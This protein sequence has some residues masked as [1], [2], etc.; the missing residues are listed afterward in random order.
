MST[1]KAIHEKVLN[2]TT[3]EELAA[4]YSEWAEKYDHDLLNEMEYVAPGITG[5]LLLSHLTDTS[6]TILDAGCG[7]GIVGEYLHGHG[8]RAID[9]LDYSTEMLEKAREKQVYRRLMQG[10]L[11]DRLDIADNTYDAIISVG[12]FTCGHVG[13][14]AFDELIRITKPGGYFCLTVREEAWGKDNY[15]TRI[16]KLIQAGAWKPLAENTVDYIRQEGSSC[17]ACLFEISV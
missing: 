15:H 12:T 7:T 13:P 16:E 17:K 8:F 2:A 10:D 11:T 3:K 1:R 5:D 4:A 6:A 9:G 14:E